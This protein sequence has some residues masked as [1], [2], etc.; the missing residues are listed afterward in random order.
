MGYK[1]TLEE[2]VGVL[3]TLK[4]STLS[5]DYPIAATKEGWALRAVKNSD[6]ISDKQKS[7]L[8]A[9]FRIGQTTG[10]T[11]NAEVIAREMRHARGADCKQLF[12]SSASQI[13]SY[14]LHLNAAAGQQDLAELDIQASEEDTN[15]TIARKVAATASQI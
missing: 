4:T 6:R 10:R 7:S 12:Q 5:K 13:T 1:S 3:P 11:L 8:L 14:F 2:G 9:K 15:F